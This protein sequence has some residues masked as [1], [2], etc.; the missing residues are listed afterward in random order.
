MREPSTSFLGMFLE[1]VPC[2]TLHICVSRNKNREKMTCPL[3]PIWLTQW[4][5][6]SCQSIDPTPIAILNDVQTEWLMDNRQES[7]GYRPILQPLSRSPP[8]STLLT[9]HTAA[10]EQVLS[11]LY[12]SFNYYV[13]VCFVSAVGSTRNHC[14]LLHSG[15]STHLLAL[16]PLPPLCPTCWVPYTQ[17]RCHPTLFTHTCAPTSGW[18]LVERLTWKSVFE[19][20]LLP[21]SITPYFPLSCLPSLFPSNN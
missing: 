15:C 20:A 16:V 13:F 11:L 18:G 12:C 19:C 5:T 6:L 1:T 4:N 17:V 9:V 3:I 21:I 2:L 14:N 8:G 10:W 7:C